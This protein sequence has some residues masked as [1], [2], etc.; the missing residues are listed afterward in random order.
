MPHVRIC[1]DGCSIWILFRRFRRYRTYSVLVLEWAINTLRLHVGKVVVCEASLFWQETS[2]FWTNLPGGAVCFG[3]VVK[4][5]W[6][7]LAHV[8]SNLAS[9]GPQ[10][11]NFCVRTN[12]GGSN[13]IYIQML[14]RHQ[15]SLHV[16]PI[17]APIGPKFSPIWATLGQRCTQYVWTISTLQTTTSRAESAW[18]TTT[19]RLKNNKTNWIPPKITTITKSLTS[20]TLRCESNKLRPS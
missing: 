18:R 13:N 17:W 9:M 11:G 6:R 7:N 3:P 15:S 16:R 4:V 12:C 20:K 19:T 14:F 2:Q 5:F 10:L 8:W 1:Q